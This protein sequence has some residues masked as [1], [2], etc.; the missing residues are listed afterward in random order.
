MT[1]SSKNASAPSAPVMTLYPSRRVQSAPGPV[2][3]KQSFRDEC[4]I[5]NIL[6]KYQRTGA[7]TH[8]NRY[9]P[10]YGYAP[11]T[12]F[13]EALEVVKQGSEMFRAL[14][15]SIRK[16]FDND[17]AQFLEF[18]QDPSNTAEAVSLGLATSRPTPTTPEAPKAPEPSPSAS[19]IAQQARNPSAWPPRICLQIRRGASRNRSPG[20]AGR[21]QG[22]FAPLVVKWTTDRK[23]AIVRAP[24]PPPSSP[25]DPPMRRNKMTRSGSK[26]LFTATASRTHR[27]NVN[28]NPMRG[29]IRL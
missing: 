5:N 1:N 7:L 27:K 15:S 9:S 16:R 22:P 17:P 13:R 19:C 23:P 29:G 3:A 28:P 24:V 25:G 14:P 20:A 6:A 11:S 18:I 21:A 2:R 4:N 12:D 26:S 8:V 10:Q